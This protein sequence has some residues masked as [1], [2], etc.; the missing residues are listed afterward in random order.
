MKQDSLAGLIQRMSQAIVGQD[1]DRGGLETP[2]ME[3]REFIEQRRRQGNQLVFRRIAFKMALLLLLAFVSS[4]V[5]H[6]RLF[7]TFLMICA[8]ISLS[9]ALLT[10]EKWSAVSLNRW[11]EALIFLTAALGLRILA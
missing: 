7:E 10:Q 5:D 9:F 1:G 4:S 6:V 2:A 3:D 11:D 8:N